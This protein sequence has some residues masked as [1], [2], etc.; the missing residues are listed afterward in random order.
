MKIRDKYLKLKDMAFFTKMV[1]KSVFATMHMENQGF[2]K[3]RIREIIK[4]VQKQ[5]GL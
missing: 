4:K 3:E 5:K 2:P 1:E